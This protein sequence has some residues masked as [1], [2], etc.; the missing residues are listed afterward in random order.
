MDNKEVLKEIER[1]LER[2]PGDTPWLRCIECYNNR[3][4]IE[5]EILLAA[6]KFIKGWRNEKGPFG[7]L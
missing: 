6:E 1:R 3:P 4:C 5:K 7:A 2:H